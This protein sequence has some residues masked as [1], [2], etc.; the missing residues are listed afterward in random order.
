MQFCFTW[1]M[2]KKKRDFLIYNDY[3]TYNS[4][5]IYKILIN[6]IYGCCKKANNYLQ[7]KFS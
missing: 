7:E 5:K 1:A 4:R 6:K 2:N 3:K